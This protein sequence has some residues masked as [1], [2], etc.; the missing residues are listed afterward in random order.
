MGEKTKIAIGV[1]VGIAVGAGA[2]YGYQY[3]KNSKDDSGAADPH[4]EDL[5]SKEPTP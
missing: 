3:Y 1:A 5:S 2:Y 4:T